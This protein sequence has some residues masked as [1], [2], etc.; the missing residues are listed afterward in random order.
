MQPQPLDLLIDSV[1]AAADKQLPQNR[2]ADHRADDD[3][4]DLRVEAIE[5]ANRAGDVWRFAHVLAVVAGAVRQLRVAV[6]CA[7]S[8]H[9][10]VARVS[11]RVQRHGLAQRHS[12]LLLVKAI[13]LGLLTPGAGL[14][15]EGHLSVAERFK[16]ESH[17]GERLVLAV[18]AQEVEER[19]TALD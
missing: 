14:S 1:A 11:L 19:Q 12:F 2:E 13:L 16:L 4:G 5:E 7:I 3:P 18:H 10:V 15:V 8:W 9:A 6:D 17:D